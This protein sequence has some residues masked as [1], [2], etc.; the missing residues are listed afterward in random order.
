[1]STVKSYR[2]LYSNL[3]RDKPGESR[4]LADFSDSDVDDSASDGM[5]P[6]N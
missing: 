4:E 6:L 3:H 5:L 1:M 2:V